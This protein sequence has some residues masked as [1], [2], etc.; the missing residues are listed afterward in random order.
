MLDMKANSTKDVIPT[1]QYHDRQIQ[2]SVL[3]QFLALGASDASGS[4]AVSTDHSKLFLL[5]EEAVAKNIQS[6]IQAQLIKQL[7]DLNFANLP[8]GYPKLVFSKIGDDEDVVATAT[9]IKELMLA[10]AITAEPE[11]EE[12]LRER[13]RLPGLPEA[14]KEAF[15]Y[16]QQQAAKD[17]K[18]G[19]KPTPKLKPGEE[20]KPTDLKP[21]DKNAN[22]DKQKQEIEASAIANG[23]VAKQQLLAV[24]MAQ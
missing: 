17:R 21:E 9:A 10:G 19:V 13:L 12:N 1:I 18:A 15:E 22:P 11:T 23:E 20:P 16:E 3:A 2:L 24:I 4:R 8:N 5:S 14:F 6:A 7:C